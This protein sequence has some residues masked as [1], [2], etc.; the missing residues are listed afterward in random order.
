MTIT[1]KKTTTITVVG[2]HTNKNCKPVFCIT[3]G[4]IYASVYDAAAFNGATNGNMSAHL[5][6]RSNSCKGKKFCLV[7]NMTDHAEEIAESMSVKHT[8]AKA[9]DAIIAKQ[10]ADRKAAEELARRKENCAKLRAALEEEERLLAEAE[11]KV[12]GN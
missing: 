5:C 8:K 10:E 9:Y 6:G 7:A 3:T 12:G 2:T 11:N 4:E 1:T